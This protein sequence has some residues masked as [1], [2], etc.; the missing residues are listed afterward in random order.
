MSALW[1]SALKRLCYKS[2]TSKTF[3]SKAYCPSCRDVRFIFIMVCPS[4]RDST[5]IHLRFRIESNKFELIVTLF[6]ESCLFLSDQLSI[7]CFIQKGRNIP[8]FFHRRKGRWYFCF[9]FSMILGIVSLYLI[10]K[11]ISGWRMC[12]N[13]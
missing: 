10:D 4:Y 8:L 12:S 6:L 13:M 11:F 5:V 9:S 7:F 2:F 1:V 3:R